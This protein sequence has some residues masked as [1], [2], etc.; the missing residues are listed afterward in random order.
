MST[1]PHY[2]EGFAGMPL[3]LATTIVRY[4]GK[5]KFNLLQQAM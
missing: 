5:L 4:C 1:D 2:M 3:L